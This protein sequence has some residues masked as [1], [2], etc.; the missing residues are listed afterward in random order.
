MVKCMEKL[1]VELMESE[2]LVN[3][4]LDGEDSKAEGAAII[5]LPQW[6]PLSPLGQS[7]KYTVCFGP[8]IQFF[9]VSSIPKAIEKINEI[10]AT[11][12]RKVIPRLLFGRNCSQR[13]RTQLTNGIKKEVV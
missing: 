2:S 12:K 11:A 1:L 5:L 8:A 6:S 13:T 9:A 7:A 10:L 3:I 4:Y